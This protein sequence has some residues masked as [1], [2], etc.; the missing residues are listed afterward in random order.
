V[1]VRA[2]ISDGAAV[3][4]VYA[5]DFVITVAPAATGSPESTG[6]SQTMMY[7]GL[8]VAVAIIGLGAVMLFLRKP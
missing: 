8:G 7:V 1:T 2:T 5:Q 3:G 6:E 4:T